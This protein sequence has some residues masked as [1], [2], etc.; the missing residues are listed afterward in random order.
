M[1]PIEPLMVEHRLIERMMTQ[2]EG[3]LDSLK[4]GRDPNVERLEMGVVFLRDFL[5]G[6]HHE[7]ENILFS[8]YEKKDLSPTMGWMLK[9]LIREHERSMEA[10][11][12]LEEGLKASRRGE[13]HFLEIAKSLRFLIRIYRKHIDTEEGG[14]FIM[15]M[16]LL[17]VREM[18]SIM[19]DFEDIDRDWDR[20]RYV[21]MVERMET[22]EIDGP[23][24][25]AS[26]G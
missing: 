16:E 3:E 20:E 13:N 24:D 10:V 2:L 7:K 22:N 6:I 8:Y 23:D 12:V 1:T 21:G 11:G 4:E 14:F 25:T 17:S 9:N 5:S 18:D 19:M 15:G 26:S